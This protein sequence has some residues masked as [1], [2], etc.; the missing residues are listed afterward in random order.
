MADKMRDY[1]GCSGAEADEDPPDT[2]PAAAGNAPHLQPPP[3]EHDW[4]S[5][6]PTQQLPPPSPP[7]PPPTPPAGLPKFTAQRPARSS[8]T[9]RGR[10]AVDGVVIGRVFRGYATAVARAITRIQ[11]S[12]RQ[13]FGPRCSPPPPPPLPV[14]PP[15]SPV[16]RPDS[17]R[18]SP[19][20]GPSEAATALR[21]TRIGGEASPLSPPMPLR[22]ELSTAAD[23][24]ETAD[25]AG[26]VQAPGPAD[27]LPPAAGW[28]GVWPSGAGPWVAWDRKGQRLERGKGPR[29]RGATGCRRDSVRRRSA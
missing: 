8:S 7:P 26:L 12:D 1:R 10:V 15:A 28:A 18:A 21:A 23:S 4:R 14:T 2:D 9:G 6:S 11:L 20:L 19:A 16:Q 22:A 27:S 17:G 24:F 13:H 29:G 3:L 5:F 25:A